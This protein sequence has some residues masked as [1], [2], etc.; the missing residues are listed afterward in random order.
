MKKMSKIQYLAELPIY[1]WQSLDQSPKI[2]LKNIAKNN[3]MEHRPNW[4]ASKY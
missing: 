3:S 1:I 4:K 2:Y